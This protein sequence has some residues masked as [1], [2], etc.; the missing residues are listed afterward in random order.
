[1]IRYLSKYISRDFF[2]RT[3]KL[4]VRLHLDYG[5]II[6]HNFDSEL[7][8]EFTKKLETVQYTAALAVSGAWRGT[9]KSKLYEELGWEYLCHRR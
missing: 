7:T 5:N 1:M 4:Y 2:D 9:G 6:Y 3:Y 8:L